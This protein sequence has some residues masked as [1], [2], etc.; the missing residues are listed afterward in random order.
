MEAD[1]SLS[2]EAFRQLAAL[3]HAFFEAKDNVRKQQIGL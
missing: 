1:G 3:L 2:Q